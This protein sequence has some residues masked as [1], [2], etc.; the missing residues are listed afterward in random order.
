MKILYLDVSAGAAGDMLA[1]ALL[2]LL[3]ERE[4][5]EF[6]ARFDALRLP[7]VTAR[8]ESASQCGLTGTQFRVT[9]FGA[10]EGPGGPAAHHH[11]HTHEHEHTHTHFA[12]IAA[13]IGAMGLERGAAEQVLA[14]YRA[15][16]AAEGKAHGVAVEDVHFHEVGRADA[17]ADI[18]AA[19]LLLGL[20]APDRIVA[21]PVAVGRGTVQC[22]HGL[23]PVPAPATAE[24]LRGIPVT[25]GPGEGELC[26][27]TGA[28]LL[29]QFARAFGPVPD[30]T[31]LATGYGFG[32]REFPDHP[33]C[34]RA[35]LGE[36]A[37]QTQTE[38]VV[39]LQCN[40][41][42]MTPEAV[43]YALERLYAAGAVEA[44]TL[45][46]GMKKN[47]P[48][49]L[50]TALC[51]PAERQVVLAAMLRHTS[52]LGVRERTLLRHVLPREVGCVE[53]AYGPVRCK[54]APG[55][56]KWEYD[57]L[58]RIASERDIPLDALRRELDE[59]W[60]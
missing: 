47:R 2:D 10:E 22:A 32:A 29:A 19:V 42:D 21:S 55:R 50:L 33:N 12:D 36:D 54:T 58:A 30:M 28:A 59:Q 45:P 14:V 46:A 1:G 16:A 52:T 18:T 25:A 4:R 37:E 24:L 40:L 23:L 17:L 39:E 34:V 6:F 11:E 41:D 43:G 31:L 5:A 3:P 13:Q 38:Q 51:R 44:F 53:T 20:L 8:A 56:R 57:D 27:P 48:G 26:T 49:V 60:S 9:A 15:I 7:G 35:M